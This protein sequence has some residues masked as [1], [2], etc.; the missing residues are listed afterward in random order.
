[1]ANEARA[2]RREAILQAAFTEFRR[3]GYDRATMEDIARRAGIG[4]STVYEYFP[5]KLELLTATGDFIMRQVLLDIERILSPGRM[6]RP[7]LADYFEYIGG[8]M[9][10]IGPSFLQVAGDR[11]VTETVHALCVQY[12]NFTAA[13]MKRVLLAAQERGEVSAG[14][15]VETAATMLVTM[16]NPPFIQL[17]TKGELHAAVDRVVDLLLEGLAP[18]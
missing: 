4:K 18:R 1:M 2:R 14:A 10:E 8:V 6:F 15:N 11:Q 5:S 13:Q 9:G 17:M 12:M 16:P 7:A 3:S